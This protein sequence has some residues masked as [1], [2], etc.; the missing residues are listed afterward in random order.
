MGSEPLQTERCASTT[1]ATCLASGSAPRA[2]LIC[3]YRETVITTAFCPGAIVPGSVIGQGRGNVSANAT[4]TATTRLPENITAMFTSATDNST[5]ASI[6]DIQYRSWR[7]QSSKDFDNGK[8]YP[9]GMYRH[10]DLLISRD[11]LVLVEGAVVDAKS[12]GIGFRNHTAP[13]GLQY[14]AQWDEDILW[15]E[16]E[17]SC[18]NT[19]LSFQMT[20]NDVLNSSYPL[21]ALEVVD[22]GGFAL[23]R[24]GDPYAGWPNITYSSPDVQLR[25]DRSAWLSNFLAAFTFNL[26]G[27]ASAKYGLNATLGHHYPLQ[28]NGS[29]AKSMVPLSVR[30]DYLSG[31]WLDLSSSIRFASNGSL[32]AN[33]RVLSPKNEYPYELA[34][35]LF[36]ELGGRCSGRINDA[37]MEI[38]HNVECGFFFGAPSKID[39]GNPLVQEAG[40]KWKTPIYVCAGAVKAS[41]KTVS[42]A[43]NGSASLESLVAREVKDKQY[44]DPADHP[45][46]AIEDWWYPGSEGAHA[47][48]LWGIVDGSYEGTA[49]YNFTR[50]P[51]LYLPYSYY[52]L[53]WAADTG[54]PS[55]ILA[56]PVAP[57]GILGQVLNNVFTPALQAL[58]FP[59]YRGTDSLVLQA[60]WSDLSRTQDGVQKLLCLVWTDIMASATVGTNSRGATPRASAAESSPAAGSTGSVTVYARRIS[61]D[62]RYAIPAILLL[63]AWV[64]LL[65]VGFI[66]GVIHRRLPT[67]LK[68]LLND[69]SVGRVAASATDPSGKAFMRSPTSKWLD[70]VGHIPLQLGNESK[71]RDLEQPSPAKEDEQGAPLPFDPLLLPQRQ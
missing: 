66:L 57:Y 59:R 7:P 63:A 38:D 60:K 44:T 20:V 12:G 45:L 16:P 24:H 11:N 62:M 15:I 53:T 40:S 2:V 65:L 30:T 33:G 54:G 48:P 41:I 5:V 27:T 3:R 37:S 19:N 46:W 67:H 49:G 31:S 22:D 43:T 29:R 68:Q 13:F 39:G 42:F 58:N 71:S 50:A 26:T 25:A 52:T 10:V 1:C 28:M 17:I 35:A 18:A 47:A 4:L 61:Y 56:G 21:Q 23:L 8:P 34:T 14:G 9:K 6:L 51:S 32:T 69:T 36:S 64:M 55:D 70:A